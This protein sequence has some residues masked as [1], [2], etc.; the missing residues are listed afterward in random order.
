M[1]SGVP[2]H[3]R[4]RV[5]ISTD[6]T[7]NEKQHRVTRTGLSG[8]ESARSAPPA[9]KLLLY[10]DIVQNVVAVTVGAEGLTFTD[11]QNDRKS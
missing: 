1:L 11:P 9:V 2:N 7:R 6:C 10:W 4:D 5:K 8:P 3:G